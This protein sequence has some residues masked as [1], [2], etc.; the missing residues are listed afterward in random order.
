MSLPTNRRPVMQ[1]SASGVGVGSG[2]SGDDEQRKAARSSV[3]FLLL[4]RD[5]TRPVSLW[6]AA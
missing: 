2:Q 5:F 4:R 3:R 1:M 6:M